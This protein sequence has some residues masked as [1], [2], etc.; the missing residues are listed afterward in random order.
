MALLM[1]I[2]IVSQVKAQEYKTSIGLRAGNSW[3]L[4][5]KHFENSKV[6]LEGLLASE[7]AVSIRYDF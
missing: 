2:S 4:T 1:V 3:G 7:G 5:I 6:A